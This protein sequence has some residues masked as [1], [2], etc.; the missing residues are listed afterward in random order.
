MSQGPA[1]DAR[2]K[3]A[4]SL[5]CASEVGLSML[6]PHKGTVKIFFASDSVEAK[7]HALSFVGSHP[8]VEV[9]EIN[10]DPE[11]SDQKHIEGD[12]WRYWGD[13]LVL[14]RM[15]ALVSMTSDFSQVPAQIAFLPFARNMRFNETSCVG[16]RDVS[17]LGGTI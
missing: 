2:E 16:I 12:P 13:F 6:G 10:L 3:V 11:H 1:S 15:H 9:F 14:S 7:R 8:N 4:Q 5:R 17:G